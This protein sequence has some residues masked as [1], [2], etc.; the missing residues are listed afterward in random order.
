MFNT[1]KKKAGKKKSDAET[2]HELMEQFLDAEERRVMAGLKDAGSHRRRKVSMRVLSDFL[3]DNGIKYPSQITNITFEEYPVYRSSVMKSTIKS[4][5]RDIGVFFRS[6]LAPRG[7]ISNEMLSSRTF[8]PKIVIQDSEL[9]ANPA[10]SPND[11]RL[12]NNYIRNEW[13]K[14]AQTHRGMYSRQFMW[15]FVHLLKCSGMRPKEM[16][17]IRR[18]D[19]TLTNPKRW[20]ETKQEFEDNYKL[21]IHVRKS[22]TGKRRD[23]VCRSNAGARLRDFLIYQRQYIEAHFPGVTITDESLIFGKPDE[24]FEKGYAYTYWQQRWREY[25]I[26]PLSNKLEGNKFSERNYTLYSLRSSFVED[27][28][29]D[30]LDIYL[31]ARLAGNSVQVIQKYYDRHNVIDRMEE[32]QAIDYGKRKPPAVETIN[33]LEL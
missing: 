16:L 24:F 1:T 19:I 2:F 10:I 15:C 31:I 23:V 29:R 12:I 11:Y 5:L 25:I 20:S 18:K 3:A 22:K 30:G 13:M 9:D 21:T 14:T 6:F 32:I 7:Y 26:N 28:I 33:P 17:D 8:F 27:C 4:E